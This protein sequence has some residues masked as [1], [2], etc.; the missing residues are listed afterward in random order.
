MTNKPNLTYLIQQYLDY[1][2]LEKNYSPLTLRNYKLYLGRFLRWLE[3]SLKDEISI[4]NIDNSHI[5]SYRLYLSRYVDNHNIPIKRVTQSYYIIAL[6][7]F[8]RW[9]TKQNFR[10]MSPD[11]I[12]LPKNEAH[13]LKFLS[14]EQIEGLLAQPSISTEKG[15]R[16]KAILEILFSTGL[17][18]S[19]LIS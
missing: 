4:E 7:S 11:K 19:E 8:L 3:N 9:L 12:E 13:S 2:E 5:K 6:R 16:D 18:V 10:V 15:L 1:L 14:S 17:R